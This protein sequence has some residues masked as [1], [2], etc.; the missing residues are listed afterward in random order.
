MKKRTSHRAFQT[1]NGREVHKNVG[2]NDY[3]HL[4][5]FLNA[6]KDFFFL[7]AQPW[8]TNSKA[9]MNFKQLVVKEFSSNITFKAI[10]MQMSV[11]SVSLHRNTEEELN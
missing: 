9:F 3:A 10:Y 5:G 6:S 4:P 1:Q 8:L 2:L 7:T 11:V